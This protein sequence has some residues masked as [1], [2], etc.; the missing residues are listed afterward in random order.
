[1]IR[2]LLLMV[3]TLIGMSIIIFIMLRLVPGNIADILF[4]SAGFI[5]PQEKALLEKELGLDLPLWEQY[6]D[7][8]IGLVQGNLGYSY[9]SELPAIDELA[10]AFQSPQS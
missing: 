10:R 9:V 2:R 5:D 6:Y 4:D 3:L 8:I 1:M 7:W